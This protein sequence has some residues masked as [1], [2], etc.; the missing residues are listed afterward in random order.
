MAKAQ[1]YD[2]SILKLTTEQKE[3]AAKVLNESDENRENA[4]VEIKRW[5]EENNLRART[6]KNNNIMLESS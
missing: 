2:D 6:G 3:Y 1:S 5:I 4:I